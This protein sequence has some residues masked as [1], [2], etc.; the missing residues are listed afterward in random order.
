VPNEDVRSPPRDAW[1]ARLRTDAHRLEQR[2]QLERE[3]HSSIDA[4][5]VMAELD[6]EVG[7]GII[8]GALAFRFFIWLL[9]AALV[10]VAGLGTAEQRS[11]RAGAGS[12]GR[13]A[14]L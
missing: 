4:L 2:A 10:A 3:R 6:G 9:P 5:F 7:G 12:R 1:P 8:A 13:R 11:V 14:E